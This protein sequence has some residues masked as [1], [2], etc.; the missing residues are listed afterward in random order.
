[1]GASEKIILLA[2]RSIAHIYKPTPGMEHPTFDD[3]EAVI[4]QL[5]EVS[6]IPTA[7]HWCGH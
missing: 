7:D 2:D 6:S 3:L 1:M 4:A 5:T